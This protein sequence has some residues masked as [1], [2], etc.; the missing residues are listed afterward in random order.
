MS[1]SFENFSAEFKEKYGIDVDL[2]TYKKIVADEKRAKDIQEEAKGIAGSGYVCEESNAK[3]VECSSGLSYIE[4]M[5]Y[6][7]RC[8]FCCQEVKNIAWVTFLVCCYYDLLIYRAILRLKGNKGI[9]GARI[10]KFS[11][12]DLRGCL[13]VLGFIDSNQIKKIG[14]KRRLLKEINSFDKGRK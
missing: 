7:N 2:E 8:I 13:G 14:D 6:G 11:F 4:H 1:Q 3:C 5:L 12:S 9:G 10:A